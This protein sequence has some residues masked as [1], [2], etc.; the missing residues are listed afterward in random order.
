MAL[1]MGTKLRDKL[2]AR[3]VKW[4]LYERLELSSLDSDEEDLSLFSFT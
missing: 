3:P 4:E 1:K 2:F